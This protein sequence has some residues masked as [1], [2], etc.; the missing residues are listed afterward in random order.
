MADS[1][2]ELVQEAWK[3]MLAWCQEYAPDS[4]D[5]DGPVADEALREAQ[6][7]TQSTWPEQLIEWLRLRD[8]ARGSAAVI[9]PGF[10]PLGVKEI[11]EYRAMLTQVAEEVFATDEIDAWEA[12]EA[13]SLA[14]GFCR[15]WV[16]FAANFGGGFL[17]VD[18]RAGALKG[19]VA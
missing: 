12:E 9:P 6:A 8:G 18:L 16:P 4:A 15:S 7:F 11:I 5:F 1:R 2:V 14:S 3:E 13:G 19:C 17:F 10:A